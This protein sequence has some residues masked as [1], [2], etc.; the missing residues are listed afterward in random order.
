MEDI[1][2]VTRDEYTGFIMEL[3]KAMMDVTISYEEDLA[4]EKIFSKKTG[5]LLCTRVL[6]NEEEPHYFIYD[7]PEQEEKIPPKAVL[8]INITTKEEAQSLFD[9]LNKMQLEAKHD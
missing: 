8:K 2:E 5:K 6:S 7:M 4:I 3:N 1:Y 9:A